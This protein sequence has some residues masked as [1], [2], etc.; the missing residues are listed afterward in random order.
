[1]KK[2]SLRQMA[3]AAEK[4]AY[5]ETIA[6]EKAKCKAFAPLTSRFIRIV[7]RYQARVRL[8]SGT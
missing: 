4:A 7:N 6:Q 8:A 3:N 5:L 1:M 2:Q